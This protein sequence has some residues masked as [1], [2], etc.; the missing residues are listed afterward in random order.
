MLVKEVGGA[1]RYRDG[2]AE[3]ANQRK[4]NVRITARQVMRVRVEVKVRRVRLTMH[5]ST[6]LP[7]LDL[8]PSDHTLSLQIDRRLAVARLA[9]SYAVGPEPV[10]R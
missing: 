8:S 10:A 1:E 3:N 6:R 7:S 4:S 9:H 2:A 5:E